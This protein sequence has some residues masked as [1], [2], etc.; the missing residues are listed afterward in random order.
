P[1]T[2]IRFMEACSRQDEGFYWD[3]M[4]IVGY[5]PDPVKVAEPWR[6]VG[7]NISDDLARTRLEQHLGHI[8]NIA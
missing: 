6:E 1:E 2:A 5:L 3:I 8:L 4:D 7:L